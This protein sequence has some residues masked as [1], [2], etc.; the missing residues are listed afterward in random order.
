MRYFD[1]RAFAADVYGEQPR[2]RDLSLNGRN[3]TVR[4]RSCKKLADPTPVEAEA[5][6]R[7]DRF[8]WSTILNS[9][10]HFGI[11]D[12]ELVF[13]PGRSKIPTPVNT[14]PTMVGGVRMWSFG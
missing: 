1:S 14:E 2:R 5:N 8:D 9:D 10:P 11:Q 13:D 6:C 3:P 4:R 7:Q 12:G